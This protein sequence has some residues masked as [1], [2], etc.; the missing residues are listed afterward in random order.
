MAELYCDH[1][2]Y[3]SANRLGID[4]P[5]WGVPQEGDGTATAASSTAST[6]SIFL[7]GQPSASQTVS[8]CGVTFTA[9][10]SG[11]TA[12]QFNIGASLDATAQNLAAAINASVTTVAS[13]IATGTPKLRNL[14]F[15]RGPTST[16]A[17]PSATV[18]LMMRVGSAGLNSNVNNQ[19]TS[20]FGT[21]PTITQWNGGV[22]GCF[23]YFTIDS[24]MGAGSDYTILQYGVLN[25]ILA[26]S[27]GTTTLSDSIYVRTGTNKTIAPSL[28]T[29]TT[30][31]RATSYQPRIYFDTNTKWT[32]DD[33][34]GVLTINVTFNNNAF[35]LSLVQILN[36]Q[37]FSVCLRR[38]NFKINAVHSTTASI[39]VNA[40]T[41]GGNCYVEGWNF[42]DNNTSGFANISLVPS[43][44]MNNLGNATY[45]NCDYTRPVAQATIPVL[46]SLVPSGTIPR[47]KMDG[48]TFNYN[49]SGTSDP[50]ALFNYNTSGGVG[51]SQISFTNCQF[52]ATGYS[53]GLTM[54]PAGVPSFA[55]STLNYYE[56]RFENCSGLRYPTAFM[57]LVTATAMI[58]Q[59]IHNLYM[60]L[61]TVGFRFENARGMCDWNPTDT[62]P[63]QSA[64]LPDGS[65]SWSLRT[66]WVA[67]GSLTALAPFSTPAFRIYNRLATAVRTVGLELAVPSALTF[68]DT[69]KMWVSYTDSTGVYRVESASVVSASS[70]SWSNLGSNVTKKV[71]LTTAYAIQTNTEILVSLDFVGAPS[72]GSNATL[73]I[74][75]DPT[76]A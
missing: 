46:M 62:P 2:A 3:G 43:I 64:K 55:T 53:G 52:N 56:F 59:D 45:R 42:V 58:D 41:N 69:I 16:P 47:V 5:T 51:P 74:N 67:N 39:I 24:T 12:N 19:I 30:V 68:S 32:G 70:A 18:Q 61:G 28:T 65:T 6:A 27:G 22:G 50:G 21:A 23:G 76:L 36:T 14:V 37:F 8:I 31:S 1:G 25:G 10:A 20:T 72:T 13:T 38:G 29:T 33:P 15:A 11:A 40:L 44:S 17:A 63:T 35:N 71:T 9:V 54:F 75:P 49:I 66:L 34:N 73:Y 57:G 4:T 26:H 48:C 7:N 60:N